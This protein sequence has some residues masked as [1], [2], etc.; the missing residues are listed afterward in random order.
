MKIIDY[1][2]TR[3]CLE[4]PPSPTTHFYLEEWVNYFVVVIVAANL[5]ALVEFFFKVLPMRM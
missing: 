3:G 5:N 4:P 2:V 1:G